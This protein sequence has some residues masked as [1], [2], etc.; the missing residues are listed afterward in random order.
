MI[1]EFH[2]EVFEIINA[3]GGLLEEKVNCSTKGG[4]IS[5]RS[6]LSK[7]QKKNRALTKRQKK[8]RKMNRK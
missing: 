2:K 6:T 1:N 4:Y 7:M 5:R 8:A 3:Y